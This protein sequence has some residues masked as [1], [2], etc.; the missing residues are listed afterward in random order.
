MRLSWEELINKTD[1]E[2]INL[3]GY[4]SLLNKNTHHQNLGILKPVIVR[5]FK[6]IYNISYTPEQIL[7]RK[8]NFEKNAYLYHEN[9]N[10][11]KNI[12]SYGTNSG[13]LNIQKDKN[14]LFNGLMMNISRKEFNG[15]AEREK[16]YYLQS[17]DY[18]L[19]N[20]RDGKII[21]DNKPLAFVVIVDD[22]D[23]NKIDVQDI[24]YLYDKITRNGA[25]SIG[26]RFGEMY[27]ENTFY[28][29][30]ES[31]KFILEKYFPLNQEVKITNIVNTLGK[32]PGEKERIIKNHN[33]KGR[34]ISYYKSNVELLMEDGE[35]IFYDI[36]D[37]S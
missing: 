31:Y 28:K 29:G 9:K 21:N 37:L 16:L 35:K 1:F 24:Y 3:I 20:P 36:G 25:Y 30:E 2:S 17:V 26:E 33:K 5:G 22:K 18:D 32:F 13:A 6:R 8:S 7:K 14:S 34:I 4:G 27:D 10:L 19:I 23:Q 11:E 12:L 15:Y